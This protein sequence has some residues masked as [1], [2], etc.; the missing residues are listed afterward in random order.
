[1]TT[2]CRIVLFALIV[3]VGPGAMTWADSPSSDT[4]LEEIVVTARQRSERLVDVPV[5]VEAFSAADIKAAGI[6]RPQDFLSETPGVSFVKSTEAGD[7]QV[8]IRGIN[9]GRDTEP[10]FAFVVDGVLSP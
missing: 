1:M 9:T 6:E 10:N 8:S 2:S 7:M 4:G 3:S 5:T